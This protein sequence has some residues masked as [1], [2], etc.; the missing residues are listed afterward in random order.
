VRDLQALVV[1]LGLIVWVI[2]FAPA[3]LV[4]SSDLIELPRS[5]GR[6]FDGPLLVVSFGLAG[7]A[8]WRSGSRFRFRRS[9]WLPDLLVVYLEALAF[10]AVLLTAIRSTDTRTIIA[11]PFVVAGAAMASAISFGLLREPKYLSYQQPLRRICWTL[12]RHQ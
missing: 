10:V 12:S 9:L 4:S 6:V 11:F 7:V 5:S 8:V 3:V 2:V 1:R